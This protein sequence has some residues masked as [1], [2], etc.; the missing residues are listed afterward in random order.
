[1]KYSSISL[2]YSI[3]PCSSWVQLVSYRQGHLSKNLDD[4]CHKVRLAYRHDRKA[5]WV[6]ASKLVEKWWEARD[7]LRS[8]ICSRLHEW[9]K[10]QRWSRP[11]PWASSRLQSH[12]SCQALSYSSSL[13]GSC[14]IL[15][16]L[17]DKQ[18]VELF[19]SVNSRILQL[20]LELMVTSHRYFVSCPTLSPWS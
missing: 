16:R 7:Q 8:L 4:I 3:W 14:S 13:Q 20:I 10:A 6:G 15:F 2:T 5:A 1:M 9:G 17:D 12:D 18:W 19:L 11:R